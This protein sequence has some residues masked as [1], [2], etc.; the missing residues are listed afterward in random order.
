MTTIGG[1]PAHPLIVHAVVVL[2]PLAA[3]GTLAV[4][5]RPT[6]RR[7][8]GIPVLLVGLIGLIGV[9]LATTTGEQLQHALGGG[10]LVEIHEQRADRLLP[11]A[12]AFVVLLAA[13]LVLGRRADRADHVESEMRVRSLTR[14]ATG[15]GVLAALS[16]AVVTGLVV[17]IGQ[18][19]ATAVWQS[20]TG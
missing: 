6:W 13:T 20:V 12:L 11:F 14:V 15:V 2:L 3:I 7:T 16:G 19:G 4:A 1:L 9:P 18:A 10:P 17:W 8:L 5:A